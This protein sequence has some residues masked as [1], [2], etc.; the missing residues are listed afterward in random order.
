MDV[1]EQSIE[2]HKKK[3]KVAIKSKLPLD[4]KD[5]LSIAY[6]PGVAAVCKK[7]AAEPSAVFTH[8]IKGNS[9]AVVSDGSAI[10]GLGNLGAEAA[11]PV[12]EGKAIIFKKFAN[13]EAWPIC[14]KS[15]KA[16]DII[17]TVKQIAP[18]FGA[19]NLE[20]IAAPK[21]FEVEA[22][23]QDLGIPVM[24]DDQHGT[25]V[26][27]F[28]G[29]MNAAKVTGKELSSLTVVINGAGAAG[30]AI[31]K[32]L[33]GNVKET[34]VCDTSGA[35]YEGRTENMNPF[36]QELAKITNQ[37]KT[38]GKLHEVI[39]G[40]DVFVGVSAAGALTKEMVKTMTARPFIFAM[41][42][43]VPE[44]MPEDAKAAGAAI[45]GTGRSDFPNQVNNALAYPGIFRGAIDAKATKITAGM[46]LAAA[47]AL[48]ESVQPTAD[49][50]IPSPFDKGYMKKI[51][52]AVAKQ[53]KKE[54][55]IR[56]S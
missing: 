25:A 19:I 36:K 10:L 56:A 28:A 16:E 54:G 15:Q 47:H 4:N 3:G 39:K 49:K 51:A 12:M 50:I 21:C 17:H 13:I 53:A 23:L 55:V 7:I 33:H 41:A 32:I 14:V 9:V 52:K 8:T 29:L 26:V 1:Y 38:S 11:I 5:D 40:A 20:D 45:V 27:L 30:T 24:H 44:I 37:R 31:A 6:T 42:N 43:P 2:A 34:I 48:A 22:A 46:K 35:I 18:V